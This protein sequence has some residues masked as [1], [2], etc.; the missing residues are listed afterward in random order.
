MIRIL[1]ADDHAIVC[2][3]LASVLGLQRD[4]H[5]VGTAND[6]FEAVRKARELAPDVI[7]MDLVM[8]E[9]D[10]ATAT[11]EILKERP[12]AR[13]LILTSFGAADGIAHAIDAGAAGALMKNIDDKELAE[14]IRA[15]AR[16][17]RVVAPEI[18]RLIKASPPVPE[19]TERQREIL[20]SM[21][22]GLT[23]A[24]IAV[25]LALTHS[26]IREHVSAIYAKLGAANRTEAVAI[27]LKKH[28]LEP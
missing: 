6:G 10:G 5:V 24:D 9:K 4:F 21:S 25:Q 11:A 27:A 2:M 26:G 3:G 7:L 19:L 18:A 1:I 20:L 12:G 14:A 22:R 15:V 16:G 8:P 13:I 17:E 23:D 28:L